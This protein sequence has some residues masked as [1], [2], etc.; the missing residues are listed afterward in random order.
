MVVAAGR[1]REPVYVLLVP[2]F[3][4]T[5]LSTLACLLPCIDVLGV[6]ASRGQT[7]PLR[8]AASTLKISRRDACRSLI[9]VLLCQAFD[10]GTVNS[11]REQMLLPFGGAVWRSIY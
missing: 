7:S 10:V 11:L 6:E 8:F 3:L 4:Q 2:E 1:P 9:I 5:F